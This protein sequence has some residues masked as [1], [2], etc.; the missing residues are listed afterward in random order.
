MEA[1]GS[2][3]LCQG[4]DSLGIGGCFMTSFGGIDSLQK[5]ANGISKEEEEV[6]GRSSIIFL[7]GKSF[8]TAD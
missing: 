7:A 5:L 4:T 2:Y 6:G 3:R 8:Q 1:L